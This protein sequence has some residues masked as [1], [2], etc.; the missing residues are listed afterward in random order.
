MAINYTPQVISF[1]SAGN[2]PNNIVGFNIERSVRSAAGD[3]TNI[4]STTGVLDVTFTSTPPADDAL[5]GDQLMVEGDYL[6]TIIDN[7][8]S[9]ITIS[10]ESNFD[11]ITTESFVV[12]NDLAEFSTFEIVGSITPELPFKATY[13]HQYVDSTGTMFDFYQIKS[14]DSGGTVSASALTSPFRPGQVV[15][16]AIDTPRNTP[17]DSL[18]GAIGGSITFEVTCILGG[19]RQDPS[20]HLVQASI[21]MPSYL[22]PNGVL[23][24]LDTI[25]MVRTGLGQYRATW[26]IPTSINI[27]NSAVTLYPSDDYIVSY[28]AN[29][30]GMINSAENAMQEFASEFFTIMAFDG[31]VFGRFPAYA[32]IDDLRKT[33]FEI[34]AYLP[35]AFRQT[36]VES[37]NTILQYHLETASDKLREELNMH[38]VRSMSSDRKEYVCAR[39]I[40]T[41]FMASRGQ[42]AA[43]IS[44]ELLTMWKE[45]AEYILAQLKRE[46]IAQGI[47]MGRG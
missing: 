45:R 41:I 21:M 7:T 17:Q 8:S 1:T 46:G 14:I 3:I 20:G 24:T 26:S 44:N 5:I 13:L 40:Y 39:A 23:T 15:N 43:A 10:Q 27:G 34:D 16:L 9:T 25:D 22:A 32:T 35:E 18:L 6:F 11:N 47:P 28:K 42:N 19:R 30:F 12:I 4:N 31:P 37:R 33:F 36:D 2:P 38:Q 29:F